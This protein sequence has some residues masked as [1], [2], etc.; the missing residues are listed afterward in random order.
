[1]NTKTKKL[2]SFKW[3]VCTLAL[4]VFCVN[5]IQIPMQKI[6]ATES[7]GPSRNADGT[8]TITYKYDDGEELYICGSFTSWEFQK[9]SKGE[10]NVFSYTTEVLSAGS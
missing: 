7:Y 8:V 4:I 10:N 9:M 2:K 6:S 1:M 3:I 5:M